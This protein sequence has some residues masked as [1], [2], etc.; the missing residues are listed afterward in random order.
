ME[1]RTKKLRCPIGT[2]N[3]LEIKFFKDVREFV[4]T[5]PR[6]IHML[7]QSLMV[8]ITTY[9]GQ[10]S[11]EYPLLVKELSLSDWGGGREGEIILPNF[12]YD[13]S[14]CVWVAP[15]TVAAFGKEVVLKELPRAIEH[16]WQ[17]ELW[18]MMGIAHRI[19]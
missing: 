12:G 15:Q 3:T 16:Q 18:E 13:H 2:S 7:K 9:P 19:D 4:T 10:T 11:K 17:Y 14:R 5:D 1:I 6:T 8:E